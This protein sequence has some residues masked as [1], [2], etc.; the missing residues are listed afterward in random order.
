M[1]V[2]DAVGCGVSAIPGVGA[3]VG[4]V[5][6]PGVAKTVGSCGAV[7]VASGMIVAWGGIGVAAPA[8][9]AM[10]LL[11]MLPGA[12]A[13]SKA[14]A[15]TNATANSRTSLPVLIYPATLSVISTEYL[16]GRPNPNSC[17]KPCNWRGV[18]FRTIPSSQTPLLPNRHP[19]AP[20]PTQTETVVSQHAPNGCQT[21]YAITQFPFL[22]Q[23][24]INSLPRHSESII[25]RRRVIGKTLFQPVLSLSF[26]RQRPPPICLLLVPKTRFSAD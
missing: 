11:I 24:S 1:G 7:G 9:S 19:G 21:T 5:A 3:V 17:R 26:C 23:P 20:P 25:S 4:A 18:R 13:A 16:Q 6:K 15:A 8:A 22:N 10:G 14:A 12:V 2:V